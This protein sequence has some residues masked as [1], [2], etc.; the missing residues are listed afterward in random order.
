VEIDLDAK[1]N[2]SSGIFFWRSMRMSGAG[3]ITEVPKVS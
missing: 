1:L 3:V 2:A